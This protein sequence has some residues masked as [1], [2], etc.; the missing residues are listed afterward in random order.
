VHTR[1]D[2]Q[3]VLSNPIRVYCTQVGMVWMEL[4]RLEDGGKI[5]KLGV[6]VKVVLSELVPTLRLKKSGCV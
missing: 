4:L 6:D 2:T 1:G 3:F 5:L